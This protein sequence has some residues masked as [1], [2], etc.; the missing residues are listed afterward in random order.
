MI[1]LY[2]PIDVAQALAVDG[3]L[4]AASMHVTVAYLGDAADVDAD[5]LHEVVAEL[6]A[7]KPI[8]G[9][10]SGLA[11]FTG[12]DKDVIVALVD[13]ADLEDLRRDTLDALYE[14]GIQIPREHGYAAHCSITYLDADDPAPLDRLEAGPIEFGSLSAVHGTDRTDVPLEHPMEAPAREAFAAGW[15]ASQGPMTERVRAACTAAVQT[16]IEHADDPRILEVT[17]DLGKLEGMWALLFQ[18]R[19]EQQAKHVPL[20]AAVWRDLIDRDAVADMVDRFRQQAGLTEADQD[21]PSIRTEALEAAK[22]MLHAIA[23]A[24][25]A[26]WDALRTAL[27]DA[28]AAGRAEGM[29]NAVAIAAERANRIGLDWNIAFEDAYRSLERLDEIWADMGG[30]L[31][32]T[33]D[34]AAADLGSVLAQGAEDGADRDQMIEDAMNVLTGTDVESVAFV[35]DWAMTTAADQGALDLYRSEGALRA[36]WISAGDGRVC[37]TCIDNEAGNPWPLTDFP[38]MPSHPVCRCVAAA[39]VSLSH[40]A[41]WFA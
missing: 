17:I 19:E 2:P 7:R 3:G 29:V 24:A 11:R 14:R 34:R 18:R 35:V 6:A 5:A 36:D 25:G 10:I 37:V 30:W 27:R 40:F 16:A 39:E 22:A 26:G 21:K 13:S 41:N 28:I 1:A 33:I 20:V 23:D 15:A 4:P 38:L 32:R 8:S 31:G 9:S 12:G